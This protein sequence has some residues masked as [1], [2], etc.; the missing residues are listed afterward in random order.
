M[1]PGQVWDRGILPEGS[2]WG[3]RTEGKR[4]PQRH[5]KTPKIRNGHMAHLSNWGFRHFLELPTIL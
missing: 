2:L 4:E 1:F 3:L 5:R